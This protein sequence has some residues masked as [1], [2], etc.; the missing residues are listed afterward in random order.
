MNFKYYILRPEEKYTM[1]IEGGAC[2]INLTLGLMH[3]LQFLV[4]L[5]LDHETSLLI[6]KSNNTF[7]SKL[8]LQ[9][10][11]YVFLHHFYL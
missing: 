11:K 1:F 7:Q 6:T 5:L 9:N 4:K 2:V 10:F 3:Q 8:Y